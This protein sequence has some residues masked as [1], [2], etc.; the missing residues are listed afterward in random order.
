MTDDLLWLPFVIWHYI[1]ETGDYSILDIKEPFYDNAEKQ[2]PLF[3]HCRLAIE[4]VYSRFSDR[5]LPLIGAGDWNDG[6][7]AVGLEMKGE[8]MW[9]AEFY[10]LVVD[11]FSQ[12]AEKHGDKDLAKEYAQRNAKLKEAFNKHAWDGDWFYR[13]TKDSGEKIGSKENKEGRIFIN[14]QTWSVISGIGDADKQKKAMESAAK[15]LLKNNGTLLFAPAYTV[16]DKY[17]GYLSR[18]ASGRREN[19]GV[20]THAA[21]WSV[22]AYAALKDQ[23]NAYEAY[24]RLNP[25]NNGMD[26]DKYVA[27]PYVT[28]GNIDGPDSPNYGM[29]GWT[30]YTGSASWFQKVIMDWIIGVRGTSEGLVVDPCIPADW[31]TYKVKRAYRGC[32]YNITVINDAGVT[33][34]VKYCEVDGKKQEANIIA[35]QKKESCEVKVYLG[36]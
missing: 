19:G 29:G 7:S 4:K 15:H 31:K 18:Y 22:W 2:A 6:L 32:V 16:A 24:S 23:K 36:K 20:Y 33:S 27:E 21:T 13:A 11:K 26:P 10:Y 12:L 28:P 30:W 34:G 35:P 14:A 1:E 5:G 17:I 9:L 8:S 25:V 3:E